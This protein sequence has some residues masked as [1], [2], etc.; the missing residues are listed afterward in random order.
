MSAPFGVWDT[1]GWNC[2][3]MIPRSFPSTATGA[4]SVYA[5]LEKPGGGSE[6]S[7]P[8]LIHTGIS[9]GSPLKIG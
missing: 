6:I 3:P 1:S 9:S 7:S 5:R 4:L 2:N 8:W